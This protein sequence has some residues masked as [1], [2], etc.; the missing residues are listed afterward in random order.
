MFN[1]TR[2]IGTRYAHEEL[3]LPPSLP[4]FLSP[5]PV[6][7]CCLPAARAWRLQAR[8]E[9][10]AWGQHVALTRCPGLAS[11]AARSDR[12]PVPRASFA[13]R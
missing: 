1:R 9:Q 10:S 2:D 6:R 4:P 3:F 13:L 8:R 7:Q 5:A 11:A 12:G